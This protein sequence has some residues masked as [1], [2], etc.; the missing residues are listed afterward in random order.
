MGDPETEKAALTIQAG[1]KGMMARK[2]EAE[3]EE[4]HEDEEGGVIEEV[5]DTGEMEIII[6]D[7]ANV[8]EATMDEQAGENE[9]GKFVTVS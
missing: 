3:D 5:Q 7:D 8:E 1:F 2:K 9:S 4:G 6:Q